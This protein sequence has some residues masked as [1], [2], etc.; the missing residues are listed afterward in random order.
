M[1]ADSYI[2]TTGKVLDSSSGP[3]RAMALLRLLGTTED[4]DRAAAY[5][6]AWGARDA[7]EL[8][9]FLQMCGLLAYDAKPRTNFVAQPMASAYRRP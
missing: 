7:A 5:A 1:T 8:R 6:L 4:E 3:D 9:M 2:G